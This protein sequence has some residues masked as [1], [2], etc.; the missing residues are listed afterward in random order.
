MAEELADAAAHGTVHMIFGIMM[1]VT[2]GIPGK[3]GCEW[4]TWF[5]IILH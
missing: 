2:S 4:K 1:M 3:T 5:I